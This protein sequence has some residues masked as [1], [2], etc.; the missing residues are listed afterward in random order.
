MVLCEASMRT[1]TRI[2][3]RVLATLIAAAVGTALGVG[4]CGGS[5]RTSGGCSEDNF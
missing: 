5:T 2:Y 1:K 4:G 3:A